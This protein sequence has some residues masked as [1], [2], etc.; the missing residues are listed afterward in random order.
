[1]YPVK[2]HVNEKVRAAIA[3][4][5]EKRAAIEEKFA[6]RRLEEMEKLEKLERLNDK[7]KEE[8]AAQIE[9]HTAHMK[10]QIRKMELIGNEEQAHTMRT[11]LESMT[12]R[13]QRKIE[14]L[15]EKFEKIKEHIDEKEQEKKE[16]TEEKRERKE[17]RLDKKVKKVE[18]RVEKSDFFERNRQ[19]EPEPEYED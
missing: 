4:T 2:I 5:P 13:K 17:E 1:L 10:E 16:H 9:S 6:E 14:R 12:E 11:R 18:D 15:D 19:N 3:Y 7:A 8:I